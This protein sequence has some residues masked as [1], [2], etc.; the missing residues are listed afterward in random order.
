MPSQS[1]PP[2]K[3]GRPR[4]HSSRSQARE[5]SKRRRRSR[6]GRAS[7]WHSFTSTEKELHRQGPAELDMVQFFRVTPP[8]V[9]GMVMKLTE[10]GLVTREP[11]V[12]RS[13]RVAIPEDEI[14]PL[15]DVPAPSW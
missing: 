15:E 13:L 2:R 1:P 6:T 3:E 4:R 9:H 7:S 8:S 14:P 11:G 12:A 10:L 5:A